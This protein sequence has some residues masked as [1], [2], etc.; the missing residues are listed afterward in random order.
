MKKGFLLFVILTSLF[1]RIAVSQEKATDENEDAAVRLREQAA[2][3]LRETS[4]MT[5]MLS[6]T[7]NRIGFSVR[8]AGVLW[9]L[10]EQG[11]RRL[12]QVS[13]DEVRQY[14]ARTDAEMNRIETAPEGDWGTVASSAEVRGSA[15]KMFSL[16]S[17][18][19]NA[20]DDHQ[21]EWAL[22]FLQELDQMMTSQELSRRGE[23][24]FKNLETRLLK[25]IAEKDVTKS[26][27]LG[28]Q[29]LSEGLSS[30]V[31]SLLQTIHSK[32]PEKGAEFGREV[33]DKLKSGGSGSAWLTV[34]L[35]QMGALDFEK[36]AQ[37]GTPQ[38]SIFNERALGDIA[39]VL[40][41]QI[42]GSTSPRSTRI[43]SGTMK[44]L[45]KYAPNQAAQ[46]KNDIARRSNEAARRGSVTAPSAPV[47]TASP[48]ASKQSDFNEAV[49]RLSAARA[50]YQKDLRE[51]VQGLWA[52]GV[53]PEEKRKI[54]QTAK[55]KILA[56]N[57]PDFRFSQ[58]IWL[59]GVAK[60][61]GEK[62]A[63]QMVLGD[64]E[65]M[66]NQ[67]P[68]E[69]GDFDKN[70][71][72]A[73]AY[74]GLTPDK[75]FSLLENMISPL[76]DVI[77]SY[78]RFSEFSGN[79][80]IIEDGELIVSSYGRQFT[81]Y[82]SFSSQTYKSLAEADFDRL[83]SLGDRFSRPELRIET[84]LQ[85]AGSLLAASKQTLNPNLGSGQGDG[86]VRTIA[87]D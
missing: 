67:Q 64:A 30:D 8:T 83:K 11:A 44:Y 85:I 15:N 27:E 75:S 9:D 76:N 66:I 10:D 80:R 71:N 73:N 50:D 56:V 51:T 54:I 20:L 5:P 48:V 4:Q 69:R 77:E 82:F 60:Q 3:L 53:T 55:E 45:E 41:R 74:A 24:Y 43:S 78:I 59:A 1:V 87:Y 18:L 52:E 57:N 39:D 65:N 19:I 7:E 81:R 35:F 29:K 13:M 61:V 31:I 21:P 36:S 2:E 58:L 6:S 79:R 33:V 34:R 40:V 46:I 47:A 72:L 62:E 14:V 28:R 49:K 17:N 38:R 84:R 16:I 22:Q 12:F 63:A 32:D 42:A 68:R 70:R 25:K 37:K 86:G 23:R 26:L